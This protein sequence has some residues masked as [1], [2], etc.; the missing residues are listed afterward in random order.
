MRAITAAAL[1][2]AL[3][4]STAAAQYPRQALQSTR[5]VRFGIG[6]G[7][8]VPTGDFEKAFDNGWNGQA[9]VQLAPRLLPVSLRLT[10]TFNRFDFKSSDVSVG[11]SELDGYSQVAGGLANLTYT[12]PLGPVSPYI[13]AGLG[14][15]NIKNHFDTSG[16]DETS[17]STRFA[18]NGGAGLAL[19]VMGA[20]AFIEARLA[21]VYTDKG[22]IDTR[23]IR[24]VPVTFGI[25][26]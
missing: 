19:R 17:S 26:F 1:G 16:G 5:T 13:S 2:L 12:L 25:V 18:V 7:L 14:A 8:S 24:Y 3:C 9:F 23:S 4:A 10:A 15:L 20:D 22:V 11:G 21:N 6:G